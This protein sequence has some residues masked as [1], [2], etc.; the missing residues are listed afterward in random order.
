MLEQAAEGQ[1]GGTDTGLQSGPVEVVGLPAEGCAQ[2]V[3]RTDEVLDL[4][5]GEGRFPRGVAIGHGA[6]V[7]LA[8]NIP[9]PV[10]G[11]DRHPSYAPDLELGAPEIADRGL[12]R[13]NATRVALLGTVRRD[14]APRI[15]PVEPYLVAR[16]TGGVPRKTA[17][18]RPNTPSRSAGRPRLRNRLP[19]PSL[20]L[21]GW[22]VDRRRG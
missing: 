16:R 10:V 13:L 4:G 22:H 18:A 17:T 9:C 15:S 7:D 14:G 20:S 12:A 1:R 8:A 5:A 2:P 11:V 3:E 19:A 21:I 6:T